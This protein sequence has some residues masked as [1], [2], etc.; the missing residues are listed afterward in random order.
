MRRKPADTAR[1]IAGHVRQT[2]AEESLCF[3]QYG[4]IESMEERA[5]Y[6]LVLAEREAIRWVLLNGRMAFPSKP[7][8]EVSALKPGDELVLLTTRGAYKNPTRDRTRI[9]GTATVL[10]KVAEIVPPVEISGRTFE[11]GCQIKIETLAPYS[12]GPEV[13]PLVPRIHELSGHKA[14]GMLLRRPLVPVT[15]SE[16]ALLKHALQDH[17][18]DLHAALQTY[19]DKIKISS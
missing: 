16:V 5:A 7:R 8:R 17:L 12:T 1:R 4:S 9:I 18:G 11:S 13:G 15:G 2:R 3:S 6:L 19:S 14:W 10:D